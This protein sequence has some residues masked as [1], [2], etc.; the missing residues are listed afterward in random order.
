MHLAHHQFEGLHLVL[1]LLVSHL[2]FLW[3][4]LLCLLFFFWCAQDVVQDLACFLC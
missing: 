4:D 3:L 2:L 1:K